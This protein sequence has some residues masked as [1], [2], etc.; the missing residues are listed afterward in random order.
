MTRTHFFL[1][2]AC[3][4]TQT[5][6]YIVPKQPFKA[7]NCPG[8]TV[9]IETS[10]S[11]QWLEPGIQTIKFSF[12]NSKQLE[13]DTL[14]VGYLHLTDYGQLKKVYQY[15]QPIQLSELMD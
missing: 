1:L 14:S 9:P 11:A 8:K 15:N 2:A 7:Y 3:Y 12:D 10:Q 4:I 5:Q 13:E 6:A